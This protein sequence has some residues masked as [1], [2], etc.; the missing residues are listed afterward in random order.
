[1]LVDEG[2]LKWDDPVSNYLPDLRFFDPY[3]D[4]YLT[5]RNLLTH[6]SGLGRTDLLLIPAVTGQSYDDFI[7]ARF[8]SRLK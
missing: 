6:R 5:I 2:K 7:H 3:V 8:S 1:M 4:S